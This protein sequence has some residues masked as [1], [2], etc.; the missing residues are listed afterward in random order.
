MP[1]GIPRKGEVLTRISRFWFDMIERQFGDRVQ[2]HLI[3]TD[4]ADVK[5]LDPTEHAWLNN[6]VMVCRKTEVL[7]VECIVRGY[8]TGSGWKEYQTHGSICGIDLPAGLRQCEKLPEPI[9]TPSTKAASGH[10][11]NISF[12]DAAGLVG[13]RVMQQMRD[14]SLQIYQMAHDYAAK[15]GI[16]LADTKF[17][18]GNAPG[19]SGGITLI[20]EVL[21]PD[22]SRF[23][24]ASQYTIGQEQPSFDKQ[25]VR[26]YLQQLVDAGQWNKEAPGPTL[27]HDIVANTTAR[28]LE[29]YEKLTGEPLD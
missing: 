3:S 19:P 12:A 27:P 21:T 14:L 16:I 23:W 1:N 24:P 5:G 2:H 28:Y 11:E 8:I 29:A 20:D 18:F 10:D 7:P 25:Y 15:R 17:E 6:R 22:S 26:N 9:F 13:E 4:P